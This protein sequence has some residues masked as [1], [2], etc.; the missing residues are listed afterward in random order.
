MDQPLS[1]D[2]IPELSPEMHRPDFWS[3]VSFLIRSTGLKSIRTLKD[4]RLQRDRLSRSNQLLPHV[5]TES[6][7]PLRYVQRVEERV[8]EDGKIANLKLACGRINGL[9]FETSKQFSFW[10]AV[11]RPSKAK[12]FVVGRE[13]REGCLIPTIGGGLCQLSGALYA[14][15]SAAGLTILERHG[16]TRRLQDAYFDPSRDATIFWNYVDLRFAADFRFQLEAAMS[17]Q[18]LIVRLRAE[19]PRIKPFP[20]TV[21]TETKRGDVSDCLTC[22]QRE[23][24]QHEKTAKYQ[25]AR[26][27]V[28]ADRLSPE[29]HVF[30]QEKL[31]PSD[32]VL[33]PNGMPAHSGTPLQA[34]I[35]AFPWA[36]I[37]RSLLS[38]FGP[39][40]KIAASVRIYGARTLAKS[41][42]AEVAK[43]PDSYLFIE[44]EYLP[45]LWKSGALKNRSY[46]VL[47]SRLPSSMLQKR[48]DDL[49][50]NHP[51]RA[52]LAEFRM[53]PWYVEAEDQAFAGADRIV[54]PHQEV[55]D[56]IPVCEQI[57]WVAPVV[58]HVVSKSESEP[59]AFLFPA[60]TAAREGAYEIREAAVKQGVRI[61]ALERNIEDPEFWRELDVQ[62]CAAS[63]V[64]WGEV[65]AVIHPASFISSPRLELHAIARNIPV[66]ASRGC[67]LPTQQII[68]VD[69]DSPLACAEKIEMLLQGDN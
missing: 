56:L 32:I 60:I 45:H 15:A 18:E 47:A 49:Y 16:H 9:V 67:G 40:N 25:Y 48:L 55:V 20:I 31:I 46:C 7:T 57:P 69:H 64:P 33:C 68:E 52:S 43:S 3:A 36:R 29:F 27:L 22:G 38:R 58:Q 28:L 24:Y 21:T 23:C 4:L 1:R 65:R 50:A 30:L 5:I 44:Q 14:V 34:R 8:F 37:K 12:G 51:D 35:K 19:S 6:I 41:Y 11:G 10:Q 26:H 2:P 63:S 53:D 39:R 17:D 61:I 62:F 59:I 42:Q 66:I 54:S 13:I